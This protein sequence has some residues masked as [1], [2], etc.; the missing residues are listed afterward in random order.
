MSTSLEAA[1]YQTTNIFGRLSVTQFQN[2]ALNLQIQFSH[3]YESSS[4]CRAPGA[5]LPCTHEY[6][7]MQ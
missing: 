4:W 2:E 5:A 7:Q 6:G 3:E 1:D